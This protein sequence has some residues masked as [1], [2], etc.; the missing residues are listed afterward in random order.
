MPEDKKPRFFFFCSTKTM[1]LVPSPPRWKPR[2]RGHDAATRFVCFSAQ[3]Q[4]FFGCLRTSQ[5]RR[6]MF[7]VPRISWISDARHSPF[8]VLN[9]TV[10]C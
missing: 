5:G 6:S 9:R 7:L 4:S 8:A 1:K 3:V 2:Q 10:G